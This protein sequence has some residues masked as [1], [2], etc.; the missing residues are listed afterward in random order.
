MFF[1]RLTALLKDFQSCTVVLEGGGTFGSFIEWKVQENPCLRSI[2]KAIANAVKSYRQFSQPIPSW[3]LDF[4]DPIL[5]QTMT[6]TFIYYGYPFVGDNFKAG[7][8]GFFS[9]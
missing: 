4:P 2:G 1:N 5:R 7:F 6:D 8:V 3:I 9:H